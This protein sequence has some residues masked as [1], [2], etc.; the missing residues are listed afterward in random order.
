MFSTLCHHAQMMSADIVCERMFRS[1]SSV[2]VLDA[3]FDAVRTQLRMVRQTV[4]ASNALYCIRGQAMLI[5][6][7]Q[8]L[9][10]AQH[11]ARPEAS[12]DALLLPE[13]RSCGSTTALGCGVA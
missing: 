1:P 13:C 10:S 11:R 9:L 12:S 2:A 3:V 5:L 7:C 6:A 8:R 4:P